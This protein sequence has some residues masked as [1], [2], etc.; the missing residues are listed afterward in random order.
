MTN[1]GLTERQLKIISDV[2]RPYADAIEMVGIFGSRATGKYRE[3][4]DID[5]VLYGKL[6]EADIDRL[7]TL[8]AESALP[9]TV[10]VV[11]YHLIDHPPLQAHIT[12]VIKPL[13]SK[14][15]ALGATYRD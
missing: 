12:A 14:R 6:D 11:A 7:R 2:L 8:F 1:H 4:S 9:M 5:L 10:D 13:F 3:N 15:G